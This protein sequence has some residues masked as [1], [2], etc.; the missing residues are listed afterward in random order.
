[1]VYQC[2]IEGN[3]NCTSQLLDSAGEPSV[4]VFT[5]RSV[6]SFITRVLSSKQLI[7]FMMH[8]AYNIWLSAGPTP[9]RK[10]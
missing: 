10:L 9:F 7:P 1:M 6:F 3:A 4:V 2:R 5:R 8:F